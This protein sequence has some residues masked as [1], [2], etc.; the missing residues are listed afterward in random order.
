MRERR[1]QHDRAEARDRRELGVAH[2]RAA[3]LGEARVG[4]D[5][6]DG[7]AALGADRVRVHF[8]QRRGG[9][10][11]G[12]VADLGEQALVEALRVA[13]DELQ[14]RVPDDPVRELRHGAREARA[15]DL[16]GEQQ[17]DPG[18]DPDDREHL[19][20]QARA[21]PHAVEVQDVEGF[22]RDAPRRRAHWA[23]ARTYAWSGS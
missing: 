12:D 22:H 8:Q 5:E 2:E 17:R 14:R 9:A 19:L 21:Q 16:R 23:A 13:R 7:L 18:G 11:A 3:E 15:R 4:A 1:G 6:L 20:Q 10:H